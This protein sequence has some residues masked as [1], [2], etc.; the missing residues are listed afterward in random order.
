MSFTLDLTGNLKTSLKTLYPNPPSDK[1][2][3][4]EIGAFEGR[5][6]IVLSDYL[7]SH[8]RS[9]L[10]C[11]DPFDDEYVKGNEKV[12]WWNDACKGQ[13]GRFKQNTASYPKIIECKGTSDDMIPN[14]QDKSVDFV[15]IDGD[16]SPE[17]VYKD[18]KNIF[19]KMSPGGIVLFDD[20]LWKVNNVETRLGIDK[21]LAEYKGQ[22]TILI[23]NYQLAFRVD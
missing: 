3:C 17:Q 20:Y 2:M 23:N 8:E 9:K 13:Y 11:I 22:Y 5:G 7:C 18:A 14:I 15:Y 12:A 6:S 4:V 21:F 16:H 19:P 10:L 1:L